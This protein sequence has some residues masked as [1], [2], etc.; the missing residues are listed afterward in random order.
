MI[1]LLAITTALLSCAAQTNKTN[2]NGYD[3]SKGYFFWQWKSACRR[4]PRRLE[5]VTYD[6]LQHK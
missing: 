4:W 1:K 2:D 3:M 6:Q 5:K